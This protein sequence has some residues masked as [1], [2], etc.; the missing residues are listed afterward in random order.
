MNASQNLSIL[1]SLFAGF[2]SFL[3]PCILP[4][5]PSYISYI[6]G[7]SFERFKEIESNKK[8]R[9]ITAIHSLLF[10]L[11]FSIIFV[12]LGV[13]ITYLGSFFGIS[14][15]ILRRIGGVL[16]ILFGLHITGLLNIKFLQFEKKPQ[17]VRRPLGYFSS[18]LIG[19]VFAAGWT[20]C[21]GP[22]LSSILIYATTSGDIKRAVVL[23]TFYSLGLGVPFFISSILINSFLL[24]FNK[25]KTFLKYIPVSS[26]VFL[27]IVG[28]LI[29]TGNFATIVGY[30][31]RP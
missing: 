29:F 28:I 30:L 26:G 21:M 31:M 25:A 22:I 6:T 23:L 12:A 8:L 20:P 19:M 7:I 27:I 4:L 13:S 2:L 3:S 15:V 10:I 5:L 11:G 18:V 9:N 14:Q 16:V 24:Y 1:V 17:L